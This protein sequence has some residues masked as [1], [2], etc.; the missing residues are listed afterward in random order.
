MTPP[1]WLAIGG[2]VFAW[3]CYCRDT[4]LPN[5]IAQRF[6]LIYQI[7]D[8]KYGFDEFYQTVFARGSVRLGKFLHRR[9]DA[10]LIDGM[11]V[12]GTA[13]AI[14]RISTRLR[15]IQTGFTYHYAFAMIIGLFS[16]ITV[17]V[18]L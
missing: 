11:M 2:I 8:K 17:F 3:Y 4:D 13:R 16:L 18:W 1:F 12:N 10:G 9:A 5:R 15:R 6:S 7:L 14:G